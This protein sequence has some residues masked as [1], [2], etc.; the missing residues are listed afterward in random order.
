M[1]KRPWARREDGVSASR[2]SAIPRLT[3]DPIFVTGVS[4]G[5]YRRRSIIDL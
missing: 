5:L 3:I 2:K 4:S 1:E